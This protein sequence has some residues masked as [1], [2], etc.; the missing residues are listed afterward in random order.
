M[1]TNNRVQMKYSHGVLFIRLMLLLL[2]LGHSEW[3]NAADFTLPVTA[4]I[5]EGTCQVE[6]ATSRN[7]LADYRTDND[8]D[9]NSAVNET[10]LLQGGV[11]VGNN[12]VKVQ[13]TG[14]L[15]TNSAGKAPTL[16]VT[17]GNGVMTH[18]VGY[19]FQPTTSSADARVGVV[20]LKATAAVL[21]SRGHMKVWDTRDYVLPGTAIPV[22]ARE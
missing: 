6:I 8:V 5:V 21:A 7:G 14:C 19:I 4:N 15:G 3:T 20:M 18:G 13:L 2:T 11:M 12:M 16:K 22:K 17:S 9:V 10:R 1:M